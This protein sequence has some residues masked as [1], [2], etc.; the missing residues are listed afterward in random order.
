MASEAP[1]RAHRP[2]AQLHPGASAD[3]SVGRLSSTCRGADVSR[4]SPGRVVGSS[5]GAAERDARDHMTGAPLGVGSGELQLALQASS[6]RCARHCHEVWRRLHRRW[7]TVTEVSR[8][9]EVARRLLPAGRLRAPTGRGS[10]RSSGGGEGIHANFS[11][12]HGLQMSMEC[13]RMS[14]QDLADTPK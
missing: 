5:P 8:D 2:G 7:P 12:L 3:L 11:Q 10:R 13:R 9:C 4:H 6:V 1:G 14:R